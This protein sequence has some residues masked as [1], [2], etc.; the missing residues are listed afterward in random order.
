MPIAQVHVPEPD[1]ASVNPNVASKRLEERM[2]LF[3]LE[4]GGG[5]ERNR[6]SAARMSN[7]SRAATRTKKRSAIM[8]RFAFVIDVFLNFRCVLSCCSSLSETNSYT[9][10]IIGIAM[11]SVTRR[12][13]RSSTSRS[14]NREFKPECC[15]CLLK[16]ARVI[17]IHGG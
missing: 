4:E 6:R 2:S 9:G 17:K 5:R 11:K 1:K 8:A 13:L 16:V 12:M 10:R 7:C 15:N 14:G 3:N